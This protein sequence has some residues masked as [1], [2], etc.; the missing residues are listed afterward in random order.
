MVSNHRWVRSHPNPNLTDYKN[1]KKNL[2]LQVTDR[3]HGDSLTTC[4]QQLLFSSNSKLSSATGKIKNKREVNN[5]VKSSEDAEEAP[6][7]TSVLWDALMWKP[8]CPQH[9]W[10]VTSKPPLQSPA[11]CSFSLPVPLASLD[12]SLQGMWRGIWP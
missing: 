9:A 4:E 10:G 8:R 6:D 5:N 12:P 1:G 3:K 2:P 11:W 7:G